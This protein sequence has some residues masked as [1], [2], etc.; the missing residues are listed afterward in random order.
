MEK[1]L[2]AYNHSRKLAEWAQRVQSCRESGLS[3]RQWCDENGLSAKTYYYWVSVKPPGLIDPGRET[4][5]LVIQFNE[6]AS[7]AYSG[8]RPFAQSTFVRSRV[9]A[10]RRT[11][12]RYL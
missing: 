6:Q 10:V 1:N 7:G 8:S 12:T 3:V 4:H 2:Q 5:N 11:Q 9:G